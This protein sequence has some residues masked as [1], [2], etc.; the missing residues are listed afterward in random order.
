M[1]II[2][3]FSQAFNKLTTDTINLNNES[4]LNIMEDNKEVMVYGYEHCKYKEVAASIS[5]MDIKV[6]FWNDFEEAAGRKITKFIT[7]D[8]TNLS[9][10][11]NVQKLFFAHECKRTLTELLYENFKRKEE[12]L[13][14]IHLIYCLDIEDN[15]YPFSQNS[16]LSLDPNVKNLITHKEL[17]HY[18]K[19]SENFHD[20]RI[21]EI[22]NEILHMVKLVKGPKE[23]FYLKSI[24]APWN[25]ADWKENLDERNKIKPIPTHKR[26]YVS[27]TEQLKI[28]LQQRKTSVL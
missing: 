4:V 5:K 12:G 9:S 27:L 10:A 11:E 23:S 16:L 24:N 13:P 26:N 19:M 18:Y 7:P 20:P 14:L 28:E 8:I 25:E 21:R 6:Y 1:W 22:A 15:P 2:N 17:R 3:N